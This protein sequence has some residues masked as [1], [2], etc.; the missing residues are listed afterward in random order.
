MSSDPA[1]LDDDPTIY[2]TTRTWLTDLDIGSRGVDG[3]YFAQFSDAL[4]Q[5]GYSQIIQIADEA[6]SGAKKFASLFEGMSIGVAKLLIKYAVK[7]CEK[8][9]KAIKKKHRNS[10]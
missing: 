10:A 6:D 1:N 2:P 3:Q 9:Q 4:E 5:N 8:I 7:D